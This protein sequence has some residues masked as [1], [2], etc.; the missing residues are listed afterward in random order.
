MCKLKIK[1]YKSGKY[2]IYRKKQTI[3]V[4]MIKYYT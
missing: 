2:P 1:N 4:K 3:V